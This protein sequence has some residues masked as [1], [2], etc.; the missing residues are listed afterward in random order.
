MSDPKADAEK[1][2]N[3]FLEK[4]GPKYSAACDCLRKDRDIIMSFY[5]FPAEHWRHLRTSHPIESAFA[6]IRLRHRRT[7]GCGSRKASLA[8]MFKLAKATEKRWR[9]LNGHE[10]IVALIQGKLFKDGVEQSAA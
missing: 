10:A 3:G 7:K 2:F 6:T 5:A 1:A 9:R 4:Y 8:M